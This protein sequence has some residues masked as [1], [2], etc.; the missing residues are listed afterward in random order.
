MDKI[1]GLIKFPE[2]VWGKKWEYFFQ[3]FWKKNTHVGI[4]L[5]SIL[6]GTYTSTS[7]PTHFPPQSFPTAQSSKKRK[8]IEGKGGVDFYRRLPAA[9]GHRVPLRQVQGAPAV[10]ANQQSVIANTAEPTMGPLGALPFIPSSES[11]E[12]NRLQLAKVTTLLVHKANYNH[13]LWS[14]LLS[15]A[16]D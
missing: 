13:L 8:K 12:L 7:L 4:F 2:N 1:G 3:C 14:S 5:K 9:W 10:L 11:P 15:H 16:W 6:L